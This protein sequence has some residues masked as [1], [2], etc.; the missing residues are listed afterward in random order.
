MGKAKKEILIE[1]PEKFDGLFMPARY[2]VYYGGRGG[3]KSNSFAM[4]LI[5]KAYCEG[6]RILCTR[7]FQSSIADSVY[8]LLVDKINS[9]GLSDWFNVTRT[10]ITSKAGAQFIFKGLQRSI[11]EIKSTEGIDICWVEE[12]QTI[13]E[14]SWEILIPTIRSENSEIWISFNPQEEND[15]TYQRFIVNTPPNSI[16]EKVGWQDNPFF[17]DVLDK[18]RLYMLKTDP[19]AYQHVW[20]GFCRQISDAVIFRG[21]FEISTFDAPI[22][23]TRFYYGLDFGFSQ[24]PLALIRCFI[25]NNILYIDNEAWGIGIELDDIVDYLTKRVP[26]VDKWPI[27]ADNSRP[28]TISHLRRR[29]INCEAA[30][31]WHGSIE[32][33]IAVIKGFDRI[34]IHERCKHTAEEFRLYSYKIDKQTNDILPLI[35]DKH[36]HCIDA[37]RYALSG[38]IKQS[39]FFDDCIYED[40]P[41]ART[42]CN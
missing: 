25:Q 13:S 24:D 10:E 17:P 29:G 30:P 8:R 23:E 2:K 3:A 31:K 35:E 18:E 6:L 36:N 4:P 37:L 40:F 5:A 21:K 28:E 11:Q 1:L 33:G 15:P 26:G 7:E 19:E 9:M 38:I 12:A 39:N 20:E 41:N 32:D 14:N 42:M 22:P 16:I 34:V 27:K